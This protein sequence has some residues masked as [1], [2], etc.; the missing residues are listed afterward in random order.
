M[1]STV[2]LRPTLAKQF[3]GPQMVKQAAQ[4]P[5]MMPALIMPTLRNHILQTRGAIAYDTEVTCLI[6][7]KEDKV[8]LFL[9]AKLP[10]GAFCNQQESEKL[11]TST[12]MLPDR[13]QTHYCDHT[14][15]RRRYDQHQHV[16]QHRNACEG[17]RTVSSCYQQDRYQG[18]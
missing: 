8:P 4:K 15:A 14:C 16:E 11:P 10:V 6:R 12:K 9:S 17:R 1:A 2:L 3:A 13:R 5:V 7:I 18:D